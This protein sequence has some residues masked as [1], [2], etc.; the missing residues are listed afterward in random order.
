MKMRGMEGIGWWVVG[1]V[2]GEKRRNQTTVGERR[3][4]A[5]KRERGREK[6]RERVHVL[7]FSTSLRAL[8]ETPELREWG[9]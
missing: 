2:T 1:V 8:L 9:L 5:L 6:E 3:E 4:G 7:L